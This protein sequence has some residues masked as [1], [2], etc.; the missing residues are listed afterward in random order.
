M[1]ETANFKTH[2]NFFCFRYRDTYLSLGG[3]LPAKQV[4][5]QLMGRDPSINCLIKKYSNKNSDGSNGL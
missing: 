2:D 3:S 1:L 4:F 5:R